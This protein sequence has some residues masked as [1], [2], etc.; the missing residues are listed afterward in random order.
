RSSTRFAGV[1]GK[2]DSFRYTC[3]LNAAGLPG[4]VFHA[5]RRVMEMPHKMRIILSIPPLHH[6]ICDENTMSDLRSDNGMFRGVSMRL[7]TC[8]LNPASG[9]S[10]EMPASLWRSAK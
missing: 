4:G 6:F 8:R 1:C 3:H 5:H 7:Q 9:H 10:A 2:A